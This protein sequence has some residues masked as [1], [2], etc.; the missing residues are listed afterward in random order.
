MS[1]VLWVCACVRAC[2]GGRT[3]TESVCNELDQ[4]E[5]FNWP[6]FHMSEWWHVHIRE[7]AG[8]LWTNGKD[9]SVQG[10]CSWWSEWLHL[11]L[12]LAWR[13]RTSCQ[14][15]FHY[16]SPFLFHSPC[17]LTSSAVIWVLCVTSGV[18]HPPLSLNNDTLNLIKK[19]PFTPYWWKKVR[20]S[21]YL[22][23]DHM[24]TKTN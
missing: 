14:Q 11:D 9:P 21:I 24:M 7:H 5:H 12:E 4:T 2:M 23:N 1:Q 3:R 8:C 6:G 18:F 10:G 22:L 20:N 15:S 13:S 19:F 16:S 17:I